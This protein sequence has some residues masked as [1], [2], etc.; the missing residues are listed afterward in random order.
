MALCGRCSGSWISSTQ[1]TTVQQIDQLIHRR[2]RSPQWLERRELSYTCARIRGTIVNLSEFIVS[3]GTC[4]TG[5]HILPASL[6]YF[7]HPVLFRSGF[8]IP[9]FPL[10]SDFFRVELL[11]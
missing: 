10:L 9:A 5:V 4:D 3:N 8:P 11:F 1:K 6:R 7:R 2:T